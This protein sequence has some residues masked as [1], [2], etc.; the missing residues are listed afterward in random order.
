MPK[1]GPNYG[2][3]LFCCQGKPVRVQKE[4]GGRAVCRRQRTRRRAGGGRVA[5]YSLEP[6]LF[7]AVLDE[8][9]DQGR[10]QKTVSRLVSKSRAVEVGLDELEG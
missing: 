5:F 8:F 4:P 3:L 9:A 10:Y 2:N 6:S 1:F 7:G